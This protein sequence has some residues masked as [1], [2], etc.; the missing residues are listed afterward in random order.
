MGSLSGVASSLYRRRDDV[1]YRLQKSKP[2]TATELECFHRDL[3][4]IIHETDQDWMYKRSPNI[5]GHSNFK[6][7]A[8]TVPTVEQY[9]HA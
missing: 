7:A 6:V 8:T 2:V 9:Y 1:L 4:Q 5:S 3:R